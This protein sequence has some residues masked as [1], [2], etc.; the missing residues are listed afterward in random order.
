MI[1]KSE[2]YTGIKQ[3]QNCVFP[4][5]NTRVKI[6]NIIDIR[7]IETVPKSF[8]YIQST[9]LLYSAKP[10]CGQMWFA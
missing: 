2:V 3:K 4:A 9:S 10:K 8:A 6:R 7:F 5:S 1:L